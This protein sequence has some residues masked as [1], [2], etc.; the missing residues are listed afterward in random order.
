MGS[1][2]SKAISALRATPGAACTDFAIAPR[3][4]PPGRRGRPRAAR[5]GA[6]RPLSRA[7][8]RVG[9]LLEPCDA[10][11][12]SVGREEGAVV[13]PTPSRGER[14]RGTGRR[15]ALLPGPDGTHQL[16]VRRSDVS[17]GR[18]LLVAR[19][20]RRRIHEGNDGRLRAALSRDAR[21]RVRA[22]HAG[23]APR[24]GQRRAPRLPRDDRH[25][26]R[27]ALRAARR[28]RRRVERPC[29][30]GNQVIFD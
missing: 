6:R 8:R 10:H 11:R 18:Q 23:P 7:V 26:Q 29:A 30:H 14:P 15:P 12:A 17:D 27:A 4:D 22:I 1:R 21:G 28:E 20:Q 9:G 25:R 13:P 16:V 24:I 19:R 2:A 3:G 5:R